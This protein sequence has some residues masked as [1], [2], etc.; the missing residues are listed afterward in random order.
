MCQVYS[1][2]SKKSCSSKRYFSN[3]DSKPGH[4]L[5]PKTAELV[6][7]FYNCDEVSR[8]MPG[9]KD[10]VSVKQ[11]GH[12]FQVLKRLIL[13]DQKSA[14]NCLKINSQVREWSSQNLLN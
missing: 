14:T 1:Y 7:A 8:I 3:P 11:N 5:A 6:L 2:E 9:K 10:F 4:A 12:R 13:G